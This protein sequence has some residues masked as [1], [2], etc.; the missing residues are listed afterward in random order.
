M[1][2]QRLRSFPHAEIA[3]PLSRDI[4]DQIRCHTAAPPAPAHLAP[5]AVAHKDAREMEM[6][7]TY[8]TVGK[9]QAKLHGP[10]EYS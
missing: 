4:G 7:S 8:T 9:A 5:M 10:L 6:A 1:A 3:K 2:A